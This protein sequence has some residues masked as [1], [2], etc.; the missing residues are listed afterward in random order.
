LP[1][2]SRNAIRL[3][4]L[5]DKLGDW[6][7]A[8]SEVEFHGSWC[9]RVG[10]EGRGVATILE[11][12][13]LTRLDCTT[14]S[15]ALMRQ[16]TLQAVHHARHRQAFGKRLVDQPLMKNV[17]ADLA[18]ETEAATALALRV[19]RA[20]DARERDPHEAALAR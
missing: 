13:A 4:R 7:N 12:V 18:L 1:D 6:S 5:K 16:A 14:G 15:A 20:V 17:L 11:M 9:A 2:G 19:A 8:S 3:Q 10:A